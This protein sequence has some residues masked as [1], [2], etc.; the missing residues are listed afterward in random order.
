[1]LCPSAW[2]WAPRWPEGSSA[3]R[4]SR[5]AGGSTSSSA[6]TPRCS[7]AI[8]GDYVEEVKSDKLVSSSIREMLRTLDPHSNFLETKEY[9][10]L[11]ERQKG[12]YYGL[13]HHR[14]VGRRQHH[15]GLALRGH[16]RAP[17]RASAPATSSA[18]SRTRTRAGMSIDDA[19]KRL[20]GPKGTPVH[21]T[22]VRQGYDDAAR[23]HGDPR[24]DPAALGA[25]LLH[26]RAR[27]RLHPP[28]RL[29]RDH[30]LPARARAT[31]ASASWR[32][33][34]S[35]PAAARAPRPSSSTSATTRAACSTRP[36]RSRT[37]S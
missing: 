6:S 16:A 18:G 14:A 30:R 7:G 36:S 5:G 35:E 31:T 24:R 2:L 15:G 8:E 4:R 22:I 21:I 27:T 29:Q 34:C 28:H 37:C 12:S 19:V 9:P 1:M 32:R 3:A 13:G 11:Q 23:V 17:A 25:V 20:R 26:G 10:T 33:R